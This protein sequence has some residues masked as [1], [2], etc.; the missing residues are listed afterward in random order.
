MVRRDEHFG[1]RECLNVGEVGIC[2]A[3]VHEIVKV[4]ADVSLAGMADRARSKLE[5]PE[6]V[7]DTC[8]K[9]RR[10]GCCDFQTYC[11]S[12]CYARSS[13]FPARSRR[14]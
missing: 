8:R 3:R 11:H 5:Y 6:S 4:V 2:I 1:G 10:I 9:T 13:E 7:C 14:P 12:R